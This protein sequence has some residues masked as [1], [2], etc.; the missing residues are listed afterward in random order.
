MKSQAPAQP[1]DVDQLLQ[2]SY[3]LVVE[4][5]HGASSPDSDALWNLCTPC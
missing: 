4:L 2:D 3:L 1:V 5:R